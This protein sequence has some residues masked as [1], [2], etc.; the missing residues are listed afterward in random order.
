MD[1]K[2]RRSN[3]RRTAGVQKW[4]ATLLLG[5]FV[6]AIAFTN[7][8]VFG[9]FGAVY[10]VHAQQAMWQSTVGPP[11]K[12][13]PCANVMT[14]NPALGLCTDVGVA[15]RMTDRVE[16]AIEF[17]L[18]TAAMYGFLNAATYMAQTMAYDTASWIANG[19]PASGPLFYGKN[20]GT[21]LA[22]TAKDAAGEFVAT[23]STDFTSQFG[24]NLCKPP[25]WQAVNL[26]L[27]LS[28]PDLAIPL[29]RPTPKCPWSQLTHNWSTAAASLSNADAL[30]NIGATFQMGG[31]DLSYALSLHTPLLDAIAGKEQG[32]ILDR[33]EGGGYKPVTDFVTG[34]IKTPSQTVRENFNQQL[35]YQPAANEN[36]NR[37][38]VIG[39]AFQLGFVEIGKATLSTFVNTLASKLLSKVMKGLFQP[40]TS[41]SS[42]SI[43]FTNPFAA[44][45]QTTQ[46]QQIFS[47]QF[48][49]ILTPKLTAA[50]EENVLAELQASCSGAGRTRWSCA[51][52]ANLALALTQGGMTVREALDKGF[53]N[54]NAKLIP[55]SDIEQNQDPTCAANGDRFCV[56][57]L[58]KL[59][60][61]RI[62]PIGWELAAESPAKPGAVHGRPG[63]RHVRGSPLEI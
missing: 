23:L 24:L 55:S 28:I 42:G 32:A 52:D 39:N 56:A 34:N 49:D 25:N 20:F 43:D 41:G 17:Q 11:I 3:I 21:Y 5:I 51:I 62:I 16:N 54:T 7:P 48:K 60:L 18:L 8:V 14:V 30:A 26:Q 22:D 4:G 19:G 47:E 10:E 37:M 59:R 40:S 12:P 50:E 58:R 36:Y 29:K 2:R 46:P 57:N 44:P 13:T 15:Q 63:V 61:A 45:A 1:P 6:A 27:A 33:L 31:N 9:V 38:A 53:I 35:I